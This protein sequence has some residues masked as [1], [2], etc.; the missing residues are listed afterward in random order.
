MALIVNGSIAILLDKLYL[1]MGI[2]APDF[3]LDYYIIQGKISY[4]LRKIEVFSTNAV[5]VPLT[6]LKERN[7]QINTTTKKTRI[8][9]YKYL[10]MMIIIS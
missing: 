10:M 6:L 2:F 9:N 7:K 1:L 3:S 4:S 8:H 5:I